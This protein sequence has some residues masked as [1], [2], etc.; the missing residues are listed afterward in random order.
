MDVDSG[1]QDLGCDPIS[2]GLQAD[3]T[4]GEGTVDLG[5]VAAKLMDFE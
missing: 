1:T 3:R 2:D 4:V 5:D